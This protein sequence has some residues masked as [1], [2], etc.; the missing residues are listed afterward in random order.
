MYIRRFIS[1][2]WLM[3]LWDLAW[4]MWNQQ[5]RPAGWNLRQELTLLSWGRI[6]SSS[7]KPQVFLFRADWL[8]EATTVL[9]VI[10]FTSIL[11]MNVNH[12]R[13]IPSWQCLDQWLNHW[14]LAWP[15]WHRK[16]TIT[17]PVK[18]LSFE[19][20]QHLHYYYC[21]CSSSGFALKSIFCGELNKWALLVLCVHDRELLGKEQCL[22]E[23]LKCSMPSPVLWSSGVWD[24]AQ[25]WG[26]RTVSMFWS[27][28]VPHPSEQGVRVQ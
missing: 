22:L 10:P 8:D 27:L 18:F 12:I 26:G 5:G 25:T 20:L 13:K 9:R 15:S 3:Q 23:I 21:I 2:T 7:R 6:S 11:M 28:S 16:P 1:K 24:L 19:K 14:R 17:V 4:W